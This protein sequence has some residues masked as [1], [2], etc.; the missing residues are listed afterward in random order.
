MMLSRV[1]GAV[2]VKRGYEFEIELTD[3]C[4]VLSTIFRGLN[5]SG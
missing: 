1:F 5:V 2:R 3:S 4:R